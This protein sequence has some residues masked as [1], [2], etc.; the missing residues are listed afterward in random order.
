LWFR[1]AEIAARNFCV[2]SSHCQSKAFTRNR[3][4]V[5]IGSWGSSVLGLAGAAQQR[6][7]ESRC[8]WLP[9][10]TSKDAALP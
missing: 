6:T 3:C 9:H 7:T 4:T 5:P 10:V 1:L 2:V 8:K